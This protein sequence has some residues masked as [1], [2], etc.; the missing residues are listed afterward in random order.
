MGGP[1]GSHPLL[2]SVVEIVRECLPEPAP[3]GGAALADVP[4]SDLG[5]DSLRTVGLLM[6]LESALGLE[7][8][9]ELINGETFRTV[10]T[11]SDA[12]RKVTDSDV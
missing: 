7:L 3:E 9:E 11:L 5:L 2:L 6:R 12:V 10:R 4:L 8:P 1:A